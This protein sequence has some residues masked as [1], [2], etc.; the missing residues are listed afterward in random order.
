MHMSGKVEKT[1]SAKPR[2]IKYYNK[3]KSGVD[4]MKKML[5]R[6]HCATTKIAMAAGILVKYD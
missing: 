5:G 2:M 3:T 1:Q 6:V 4:I